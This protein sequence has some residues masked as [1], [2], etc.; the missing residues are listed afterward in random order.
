MCLFLSKR[1]RTKALLLTGCDED[2]IALWGEL[3]GDGL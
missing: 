2:D 1:L 3:F